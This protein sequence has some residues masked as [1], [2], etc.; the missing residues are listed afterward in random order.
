MFPLSI[1]PFMDTQALVGAAAVNMG[2]CVSGTQTSVPTVGLLHSM[3]FLLLIFF[4][5]TS[6]LF[7]IM[8]VQ[9]FI[10]HTQYKDYLLFTP[11][12][13]LLRCFSSSHTDRGRQCLTMLWFAF[14]SW[15]VMCSLSALLLAF[16]VYFGEKLIQILSLFFCLF[17][18]FSYMSSLCILHINPI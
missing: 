5:G 8:A 7:C 14:P 12:R 9:I 10:P 17:F 13:H 11:F 18:S 4:L 1:H 16:S 3:T 6:P 2:C 15:W